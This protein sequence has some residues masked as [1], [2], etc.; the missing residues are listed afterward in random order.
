MRLPL[1]VSGTLRAAVSQA[2]FQEVAARIDV[3]RVRND[4]VY[5]VKNAFYNVLRAQAQIAVAT[6]LLNNA[7]SR[8]NDANKNYAA[9]TAPRFDVISAQRDVA[10]P[11][12]I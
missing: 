1:D 12:R 2:Q 3:N 9:G 10:T 11:S 7:L 8:L 4:V 6:D 5:N